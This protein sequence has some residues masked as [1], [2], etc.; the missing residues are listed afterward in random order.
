MVEAGD[1][2]YFDVMTLSQPVAAEIQVVKIAVVPEFKT[3][4]RLHEQ[5]IQIFHL[6]RI[7]VGPNTTD[8]LEADIR[9]TSENW[10]TLNTRQ[11]LPNKKPHNKLCRSGQL[12]D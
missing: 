1:V 8:K 6:E 9:L 4:S 10:E 12:A 5:I 2:T 3:T 7:N 11:S